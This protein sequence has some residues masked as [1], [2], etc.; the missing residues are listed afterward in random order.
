MV[1]YYV[2]LSCRSLVGYTVEPRPH[3][4]ALCYISRV[5]EFSDDYPYF[6]VWKH[7]RYTR[8]PC[9]DPR[10]LGKRRIAVLRIRII[11]RATFC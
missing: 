2:C 1:V 3:V 11:A 9:L 4:P 8:R 10:E 6:Y 5:S 7:V